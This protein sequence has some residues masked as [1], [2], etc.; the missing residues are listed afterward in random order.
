M[1]VSGSI[2][3]NLVMDEKAVRLPAAVVGCPPR[4]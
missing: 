4:R 2:S 1:I 3:G